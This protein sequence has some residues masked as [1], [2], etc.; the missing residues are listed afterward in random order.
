[1]DNTKYNASS[2]SPPL[3]KSGG[4]VCSVQLI[5]DHKMFVEGIEKIINDS[6]IAKVIGKAHTAR[7]CWEMLATEQADVLLLDIHLPDGNGIELCPQIKVKYPQI[8]I[9]ALTSFSEHAVVKRMLG[10]GADGYI[11]KNALSEEFLEGIE[12]VASGNTFLCDEVNLLLKKQADTA[13]LLTRREQE[14]L[15]LITEGYINSEIAE[16][17]IISVETVK[18]YR[19]NLLAKLDARNTAALVKIALEQKLV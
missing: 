11:L 6:G 4:A 1:M 7:A 10:N 19:K 12:V 2:Q 15:R 14:L 16:K 9:L 8:K 13:V 3:G 18:N 5:D 17:M